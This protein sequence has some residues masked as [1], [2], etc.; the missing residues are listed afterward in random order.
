MYAEIKPRN[1]FLGAAFILSL[2]IL[3]YLIF[4]K[5]GLTEIFDFIKT[6]SREH[7]IFVYSLAFATA[8]AEGTIILAMVP[9]SITILVLGAVAASGDLEISIL[10][11]LVVV[12]AFLGD[13]LG[14]FLG[15]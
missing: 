12:G 5:Y 8:I 1:L 7:K 11:P 4:N 2:S 15:R 10:Y 9:G 3:I 14:Y 13:N 6:F